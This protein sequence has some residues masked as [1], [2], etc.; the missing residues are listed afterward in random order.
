MAK[1][2]AF[3]GAARG[4][5]SP[6][7]AP[8]DEDDVNDA[9]AARATAGASGSGAGRSGAVV[10]AAVVA[11]A[12]TG[13]ARI[14]VAA[15]DSSAEEAAAKAR[16]RLAA[17][18]ADAAAR[19]KTKRLKLRHASSLVATGALDGLSWRFE[20]AR[21]T[22]LQPGEVAAASGT[23]RDGKY[24]AGAAAN[25][26]RRLF[27]SI[28][29]MAAA[30]RLPRRANVAWGG[31][32][33]VPELDAAL[34]AVLAAARVA[35]GLAPRGTQAKALPAAGVAGAAAGGDGAGSAAAAGGSGSAAGGEARGSGPSGS[36]SMPAA[37]ISLVSSSGSSSSDSDSDSDSSSDEQSEGSDDPD[38][39]VD[40]RRIAAPAAAAPAAAGQQ[41][42]GAAAP[43][44]AAAAP[45]AP[46]AAAPAPAATEAERAA[47]ERAVAAAACL[48]VVDSGARPRFDAVVRALAAAGRGGGKAL[49]VRDIAAT[50]ALD[51]LEWTFRPERGPVRVLKGAFRGGC[52]EH[53]GRRFAAFAE[54][55]RELRLPERLGDLAARTFVPE[56]GATLAQLLEAATAYA[57]GGGGGVTAVAGGG[58]GGGGA[59]AGGDSVSF[60][61]SVGAGRAKVAKRARAD[62]AAGG[63]GGEGAAAKAASVQR[64]PDA[65]EA[66][67]PWPAGRDEAPR[68]QRGGE[69][70]AWRHDADEATWRHRADDAARWQQRGYEAARPPA[71]ARPGPALPPPL[72]PPPPPPPPPP[73]AAEEF[74]AFVTNIPYATTADELR[75]CERR[76][77]LDGMFLCAAAAEP[78]PLLP[79]AVL[80]NTRTAPSRV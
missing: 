33:F 26:G 40:E 61:I 44:P 6:Y 74:R 38:W 48:G 64:P 42:A 10:G 59:A 29:E 78:P 39:R 75:E 47:A 18:A 16:E 17:V 62:R 52:W 24:A 63:G 60:G 53:G 45:A 7:G 20:A 22:R 37:V 19:A 34:D 1:A 46:A 72:P 8:G 21:G 36:R 54:L 4:A 49:L 15:F 9:A 66:A 41:A 32:F 27:S 2:P 43:A 23:F 65:G 77:P 35:M 69:I 14:G 73:V 3:G 71:A 12:A 56:A 5:L 67:W 76:G 58:G 51:G 79:S 57:G 31:R 30:L 80:M 28:D 70:V 13:A 50:G 25:G 55:R 68:Q 11:A